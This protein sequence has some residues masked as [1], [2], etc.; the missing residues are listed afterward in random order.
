MVDFYN[1]LMYSKL[2]L[3]LKYA[4][5][6]ENPSDFK[7]IENDVL[8]RLVSTTDDS[9]LPFT[10]TIS[11]PSGALLSKNSADGYKHTKSYTF[12]LEPS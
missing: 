8:D 3:C 10:S 5:L 4:P 1:L 9:E 6:K 7:N 11:L 2:R 12:G